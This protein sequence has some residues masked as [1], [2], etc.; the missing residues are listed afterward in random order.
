MEEEYTL[1][2]PCGCVALAGDDEGLIQFCE[3]HQPGH[4]ARKMIDE[5]RLI[6]AEIGDYEPSEQY[7]VS[8]ATLG[9]DL[10]IS[11]GPDG[12]LEFSYEVDDDATEEEQMQA[13]LNASEKIIGMMRNEAEEKEV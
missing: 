8:S 12:G 5:I 6:M 10:T 3:Q 1:E 13:F 4:L 2:M 11:T 9:N 7:E